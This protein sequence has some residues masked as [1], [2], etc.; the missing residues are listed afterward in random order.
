MLKRKLRFLKNY[1]TLSQRD[2]EL[3]LRMYRIEKYADIEKTKIS[4]WRAPMHYLLIGALILIRLFAKREVKVISDKRISTNKPVIYACTHIGAHDVEAAFEAI[5]KPCYLFMADARE[6]YR[7]LDGIMLYLNGVFFFDTKDKQDKQVAKARAISLLKFGGSMIIYPEGA[8]NIT[9]NEIVMP[10]YAGTAEM[11]IWTGAEI[12]PMAIERYGERY[13]VAI[14]KNLSTEGLNVDDKY[15]LT[16]LLRDTLADLKWIIWENEGIHARKDFPE[17]Y[18]EWFLNDVMHCEAA[19]YTL[20]DVLATR[21]RTKEMKELEEVRQHL[22]Q[23]VP[24]KENAFL[25][26]RC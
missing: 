7:T 25:W 14:G 11:A 2:L 8:W 4:W 1:I 26:R 10:L 15:Q 21:F 24:R 23:I 3:Y 18:S 17:N 13:V 6:I 12:V 19:T 5:K 16:N 22:D 20:E 9:E